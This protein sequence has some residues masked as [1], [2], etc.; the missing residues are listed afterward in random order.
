MASASLAYSQQPA[1]GKKSPPVTE[2]QAQARAILTLLLALTK[3][4]DN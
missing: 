1:P 2:S 3:M 4:K